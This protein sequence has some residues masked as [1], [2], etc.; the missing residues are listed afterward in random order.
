MTYNRVC[1]NIIVKRK[2]TNLSEKEKKDMSI[3]T[4]ISKEATEKYA[5]TYLAYN[6]YEKLLH[7]L[8]KKLEMDIKFYASNIFNLTNFI[9]IK[10]YGS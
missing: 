8:K 5:G 4:I 7:V 9:N 1:G 2:E 6:Y 3:Y 10:R